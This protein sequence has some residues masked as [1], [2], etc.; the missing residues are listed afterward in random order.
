MEDLGELGFWLALGIAAAAMIVSGGRKER[1]RERERQ[2]TLREM[3]RLEAEGKLMP[4]T[5]A[6]IRAREAAEHQI[7]REMM[8]LNMS[9]AA[10]AAVAIGFLAFMGGVLSMALASK[11]SESWYVPVSLLLGIW[12]GGLAIAFIV[13]FIF[14]GR[15]KAPPPGA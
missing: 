11:N 6:H 13:Y 3:M 9:G 8:G 5:L 1:E 2:A 4:E 14:R 15:K 7:W 10:S 12:A